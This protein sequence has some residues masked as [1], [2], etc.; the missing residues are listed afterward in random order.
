MKTKS[1]LSLF[2]AL[3]ISSSALIAQTVTPLNNFES[4]TPTVSAQYGASFANV[5]NPNPTGYNTTANCEKIGRTSSNWY[6]LIQFPVSFSIP[7]NTKQYIHILVNYLAQPDIAIRIDGATDIRATNIYTNFGQWQDLVFE[8]NG[9]AGGK[10]VT[11]LMILAD[12]G[13][14]NSPSGQI[15]NNTDKFGYIDEI[16]LNNNPFPLGSTYLTGN[17]LYNFEPGTVANIIG[18]NTSADTN[19][20]VTYPVA[21]PFQT[22]INMTQNVGKRTAAASTNWW[23]GFGFTFANPVQV[24]INHKYLHVMM[25]VPVDGQSV[26]FDVKQGAT[27]V[28]ADGVQTITTANTWQDVVLDVSGMAYISGMSIK[29]GN[30]GGTAAGDYYFDEIYIDGNVAPR[31]NIAT[32]LKAETDKINVYT[33][34]KTICID[35]NSNEN[36]ATIFNVNGQKILSKQIGFKELIAV[37]NSGLYFVKIGNQVTK[38]IVK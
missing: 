17:N 27:N 30:W 34:N 32:T 11:N 3:F 35:N 2:L 33:L 20:P 25:I 19:N 6:E 18:I 31:V 14:N 16:T 38:V 28:I 26:A 12:L 4:S 10:A 9:G 21:N 13:F 36:W 29:C 8:L 1:T 23:T 5:A 22:A 7:A 24:D 37:N 15:L